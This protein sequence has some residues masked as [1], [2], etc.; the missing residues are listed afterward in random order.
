MEKTINILSII[1]K[2][3]LLLNL[4]LYVLGFSKHRKGNKLL[5]AYLV[6]IF[7]CEMVFY[8]LSE[9]KMNNLFFSHY[10]LVGQFLLLGS[11]YWQL[12][13]EKYQKRIALLLL[14]GVPSVL[15]VQYIIYPE[16]YFSFNL[17]EIFITSYSLITLALLHL[18]NLLATEKKY[19]YFTTGL[20]V[21]LI[22]SVIIFLS[23]NLY[24][25]MNMKLHKE[26][27]V[28]NVLVFIVF[29]ILTLVECITMYRKK[30]NMLI[31]LL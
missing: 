19:Y 1:G 4:I 11:F 21:Y 17:F 2:A 8:I 14:F 3:F 12:F 28:L 25:V 20:L 16:K 27:W 30:L 10:Y 26:I 18:Y 6:W 22:C 7:I 5:I 29:Q 24:T 9:K 31:S 13:V 23:G 15:I